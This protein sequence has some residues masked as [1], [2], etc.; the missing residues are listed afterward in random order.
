M[1]NSLKGIVLFE[2]EIKNGNGID[3]SGKAGDEAMDPLDVEDI[4]IFFQR[5]IG[6]DLLEF[7]CLLVFREFLLPGLFT[8]GRYCSANGIPF[9]DRKSGTRETDKSAEDDEKRHDAG[10]DETASSDHGI[11]TIVEVLAFFQ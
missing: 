6:I 11:G 2:Q 9:R 8:H 3:Q 5:H 4:L 1:P 10:K 7:R